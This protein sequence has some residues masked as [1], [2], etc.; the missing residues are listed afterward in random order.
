MEN[1]T[2]RFG[3]VDW[4]TDAHAIA[5]VDQAGTRVDEF[6]VD[7]SGPG[8]EELCK[9]LVTHHV[10]RVAIERPD[11]PVVEA[12]LGAGFDVVVVA[13]GNKSDHACPTTRHFTEAFSASRERLL[14]LWLDIGRLIASF[15]RAPSGGPRAGIGHQR[16]SGRRF[17]RTSCRE[18]EH[19]PG[20]PLHDLVAGLL[21][22]AR[23]QSA[24]RCRPSSG[25][26]RPHGDSRSRS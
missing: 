24:G 13:T 22:Q 14:D 20:V 17:C 2:F 3:G 19:P 10:D 25:R 23:Q 11:G 26:S 9:R 18:I 7:H 16:L 15:R 5:V 12:L 21:V 4:A 1:D 8:L 6:E